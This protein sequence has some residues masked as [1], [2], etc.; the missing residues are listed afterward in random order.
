M[1]IKTKFK[2]DEK[3][4]CIQKVGEVVQ[5]FAD[6]I[7]NITILQ[8]SNGEIIS[9]YYMK[10][11]DVELTEDEIVAYED[12]EQLTVKVKELWEEIEG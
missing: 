11:T 8:N 7:L 3:V 5:V 2:I 6:T 12:T 9:T 4:W 10:D 1:E